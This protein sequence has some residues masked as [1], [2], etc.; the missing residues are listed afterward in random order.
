MPRTRNIA[1]K[2]IEECMILANVSA[3]KF[4]IKNKAET[5]YRVHES[6]SEE[7]LIAFQSFISERGLVLTGGLK[8]TPKDYALFMKKISERPDRLQIQT[9]LLRSMRQ[10]R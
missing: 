10:A 7:K 8:P 1:H 6:P 3:A 2:I 4:I 5:L 9:L